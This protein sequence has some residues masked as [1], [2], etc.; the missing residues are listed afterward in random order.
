MQE[1][2]LYDYEEQEDDQRTAGA[3]EILPIVPQ[4]HQT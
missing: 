3:Q 4:A 1:E 2:K